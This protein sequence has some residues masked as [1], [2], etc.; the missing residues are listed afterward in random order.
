LG[1]V[2]GVDVE[3]NTE[4]YLDKIQKKT[5]YSDTIPL[6][7]DYPWLEFKFTKNATASMELGWH[8]INSKDTAKHNIEV[9]DDEA[10]VFVKARSG[11]LPPEVRGYWGNGDDVDDAR[12]ELPEVVDNS[13]LPVDLEWTKTLVSDN[14]YRQEWRFDYTANDASL[15][16]ND[17]SA[18]KRIIID[19]TTANRDIA[20]NNRNFKIYPNPAK[21]I[22]YIESGVLV[23]NEIAIIEILGLNGNSIFQTIDFSGKADVSKLGAGCYVLKIISGKNTRQP[24]FVKR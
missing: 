3:T 2:P 10:P 11:E 24:V 1:N 20:T 17:T 23:R 5:W 16:G 7:E 14:S 21:D 8:L 4:H 9:R 12:F 22:L 6:N 13:G 19:K 15:N 18:Y